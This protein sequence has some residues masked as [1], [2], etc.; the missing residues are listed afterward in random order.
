MDLPQYPFINPVSVPAPHTFPLF[1]IIHTGGQGIHSPLPRPSPYCTPIISI[2]VRAAPSCSQR[3]KYGRELLAHTTTRPGGNKEKK[4]YYSTGLW[5]L[6]LRYPD[7]SRKDKGLSE[8]G[9]NGSDILCLSDKTWRICVHL[10]GF[11]RSV[12]KQV[13]N[14]PPPLHRPPPPLDPPLA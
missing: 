2:L 12:K 9:G 4:E 10:L 13:L 5:L 6:S 11:R 14:P 3:G 1:Q 7:S 8:R